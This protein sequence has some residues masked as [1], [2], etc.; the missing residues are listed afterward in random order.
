[1]EDQMLKSARVALTPLS[2]A[3]SPVLWQ[4][5]ND[6]EVVL[7]NSA[8]RP[9]S[10]AQH[11]EWFEAIR[12]RADVFIFGIRLIETDQLIGSCQLHSVNAVSRNAELQ[13]RLGEARDRGKG[14]DTAAVQLLLQ[15]AFGDLNMRRVY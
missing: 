6:R 4:W 13:V 10:E 15:F 7:F 8:Y 5:I 9:V 1:M 2:T 12:H 11:D 3:D 14:Y